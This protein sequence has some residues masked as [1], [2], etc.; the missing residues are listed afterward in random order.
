MFEACLMKGDVKV[1]CLVNIARASI[2]K[3]QDGDGG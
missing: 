1:D 3:D 2:E